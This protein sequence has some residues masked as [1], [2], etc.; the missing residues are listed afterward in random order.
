MNDDTTKP[1]AGT[2]ADQPDA[3]EPSAE[4]SRAARDAVRQPADP[5][6]EASF[7]RIAGLAVADPAPVRT[8]SDASRAPATRSDESVRAPDGTDD[9]LAVVERQVRRLEVA[10]VAVAALAI[11]AIAVALVVLAQR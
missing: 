3:D 9:R 11:V 6:I 2:T 1:R 8:A 7:A 4:L 5:R 10:L